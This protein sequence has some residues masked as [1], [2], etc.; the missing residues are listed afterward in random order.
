VSNF[1]AGHAPRSARDIQE[2]L[3]Q[4]SVDPDMLGEQMRLL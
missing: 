2:M 4:E 3:G 1:F